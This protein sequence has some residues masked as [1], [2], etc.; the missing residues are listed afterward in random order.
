MWRRTFPFRIIGEVGGSSP[1]KF[2]PLIA[3]AIR[4]KKLPFSEVEFWVGKPSRLHD[5]V[6]YRR[7]EESPT[8]SPEWTTELLSP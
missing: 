8:D 2:I 4:L 7:R 5:R 1:C 3:L 6:R